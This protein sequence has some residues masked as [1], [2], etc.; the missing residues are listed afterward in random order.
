MY[1]DVFLHMVKKKKKGGLSRVEILRFSDLI[2][3]CTKTLNG[4]FAPNPT[5]ALPFKLV[6]S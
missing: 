4:S 3:T 2:L 6:N 1:N 5:N